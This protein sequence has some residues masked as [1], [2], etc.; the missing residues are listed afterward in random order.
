MVDL[1]HLLELN[2]LATQETNRFPLKRDIYKSL[3]QNSG[4]HFTGIVGPRGVGKTIL[5][6]QMM[7]AFNQSFYLSC[8]TIEDDLFETIKQLNQDLGFQHFF[9]DEIHFQPHFEES[10]KKMYDFLDV[11]AFFTSSVALALY[12]SRI[13]LSRR[14]LLRELYPFSFREYL[15]FKFNVD[16]EPI[17]LDDLIEK[18]WPIELL[19]YADQFNL[20]LHGG[21]LPFALEETN[22]LQI[23]ENVVRTVIMKDIPR[24]GNVSM[25][26]L[27]MMEKMLTFIGRSSIDGIN[28]STLSRNLGITKYK[29]E[30]YIGF[31]EKAFIL[32]RVYPRGTNVLKEPKVVMSVPYRLL[33]AS[34]ESAIGGLREDYFVEKMKGMNI[35]VHYLKSTRGKKTP[36]YLLQHEGKD[37]VIEIGGKGKGREQFKGIQIEGKIILTH[38]NEVSELHR[39]LFLLGFVGKNEINS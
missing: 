36:D 31:F 1:T 37:I 32:Q 2:R 12:Q 26:E 17:D 22:P 14:V 30:Q 27:D 6:K 24:M 25:A 13:D 3:V 8:D 5:L 33:Y 9:I 23:L 21:L 16:I 15:R 39:P 18:K 11:R 20:F 29:A 34:F 19:Q 4:K 28:Y 10:L 38:S 7:Q 35:D